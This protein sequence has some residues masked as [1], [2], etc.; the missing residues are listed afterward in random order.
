MDQTNLLWSRAVRR[1]ATTTSSSQHR[2]V[3]D[4]QLLPVAVMPYGLFAGQLQVVYGPY[5]NDQLAPIEP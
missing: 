2:F 1:W 3:D 5:D 4:W